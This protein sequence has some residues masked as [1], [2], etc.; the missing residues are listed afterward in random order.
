MTGITHTPTPYTYSAAVAAGEL[1]YL[2]LH[3]GSGDDFASQFDSTFANLTAT[4]AQNGLGLDRII[5]VHVW[6]KDIQDLP[7]ME[8]RFARYFEVDHYPARMTATTEFINDD[9]LLMIE[10]VAYRG[11]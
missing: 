10:G 3:R 11:E 8:K 1:V 7:A 2:G 5:K 6:L 4:L 9:C